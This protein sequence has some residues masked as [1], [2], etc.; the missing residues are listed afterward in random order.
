ML[1]KGGNQNVVVVVAR[2]TPRSH[3][4]C[5]ANI[6]AAPDGCDELGLCARDDVVTFDDSDSSADDEQKKPTKRGKTKGASAYRR[7]WSVGEKFDESDVDEVLPKLKFKWASFRAESKENVDFQPKQA[8]TPLGNADDMS[9]MSLMQVR[10]TMPQQSSWQKQLTNAVA[11]LSVQI[12]FKTFDGALRYVLRNTEKAGRHKHGAEWKSMDW[13][14][15]VL[16]NVVLI[17]GRLHKNVMQ[18]QPVTM[19]VSI[20]FPQGPM[21]QT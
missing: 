21:A 2:A 12:W 13:L 19:R 5:W 8:N 18:Q 10:A 16:F 15:I 11:Q 1:E 20:H 9:H 3:I 4:V 17:R 14:S 7:K 6:M